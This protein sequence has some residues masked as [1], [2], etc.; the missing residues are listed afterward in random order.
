MKKQIL[1]IKRETRR[2]H[3]DSFS[4]YDHRTFNPCGSNDCNFNW[5][6]WNIKSSKSS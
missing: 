3:T 5:R 2:D 6:E 4:Y 1:A